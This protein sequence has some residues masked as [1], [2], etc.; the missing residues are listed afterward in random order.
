MGIPILGDIID[1]VGDLASEV[2][3]DKDKRDEVKY[4]L[5]ELKDRAAAREHEE[6]MGQ[7][8][9]NKVEAAHTNW[10]VAGWRPAVGWVGTVGLGYSF[11]I[12]PLISWSAR[13]IWKYG[14]DFPALD[15]NTLMVLVT[16]MLGFGGLRTYERAKGIANDPVGKN[17]PTLTA[18]PEETTTVV[19]TPST[20]EVTVT[21]PAAP[22]ARR[23]RRGFRL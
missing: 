14:G 21:P 18:E 17:G 5:E 12:E 13:V 22:P 7:V 1:A 23:K 20:S 3:V 8:E 16:G 2:L 15:T 19:T 4:K 9:V 10:F 6:L 11:V